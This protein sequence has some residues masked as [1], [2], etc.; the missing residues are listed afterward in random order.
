MKE[1][2]PEDFLIK[3]KVIKSDYT[4]DQAFP[5]NLSRDT[6]IKTVRDIVF[7]MVQYAE[8]KALI[9]HCEND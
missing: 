9:K 1:L 4:T 2:T 7:S 6:N 5:M 3:N 8:Y